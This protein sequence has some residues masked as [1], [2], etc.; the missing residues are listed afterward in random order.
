[1]L[2]GR[3]AEA[4]VTA[5]AAVDQVVVAAAAVTRGEG[6]PDGAA[7]KP[8]LVVKAQFADRRPSLPLVRGNGMTEQRARS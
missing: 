5:R 6:L 4:V 3:V 1:V 7:E 2:A 8:V